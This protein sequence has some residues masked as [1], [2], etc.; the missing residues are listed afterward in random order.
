MTDAPAGGPSWLGIGAQRCGTT[1]FVDLLTQHPLVGLSDRSGDQSIAAKELH[2]LDTMSADKGHLS[3]DLALN[4]RAAFV[5]DDI[6]RGEFTPSY[7]RSPWAANR[8][9]SSVDPD[10]V[11]VVLVRDPVERFESA[12]NLFTAEAERQG[13]PF[14]PGALRLRQM[15]AVWAGFYDEQLRL[16]REALPAN[17]FVIS[18]YAELQR[19]PQTVVER[20]WS[21]LDL[22]SHELSDTTRPSAST[23]PKRFSFDAEPGLRSSLVGLYAPSVERLSAATGLDTSGWLD[24]VSDEVA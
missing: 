1:W 6:A 4:Y 24:R 17:R 2:L 14:N 12:M 11:I 3:D 5:N 22:G 21:A 15:D 13:Q 20:V 18:D 8:A 9:R 19:T 7:L 10:C 23:A 16:W